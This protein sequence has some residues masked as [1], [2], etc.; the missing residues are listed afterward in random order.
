MDSHT[1]TQPIIRR[2]NYSLIY[3]TIMC[4]VALAV[5]FAAAALRLSSYFSPKSLENGL[6]DSYAGFVLPITLA[7]DEQMQPIKEGIL[8]KEI[9]ISDD[10][11]RTKVDGLSVYPITETDMSSGAAAG[12]VLVRDSDSGQSVDIKNLLIAPYPASLKDDK[13]SRLGTDKEPLVLIIH[14]HATESFACE[15]ENSYTAG[16]EFR[17]K[18]TE[19]NMVAVGRVMAGVLNARGIPTLHSEILHDAED[20]NASYDN[21]LATVKKY[22]QAYPS[23]KYVFDLHRDAMIRESGEA[24]KP[25]CEINGKKTAQ[26]MTLVG[27]DA[28]GAEHSMWRENNMNLAVKLQYNL[29]SEYNGMARPINLRKLSFHQQYAPGSLLFEIG[30]CGNTLEEAKNAAENL[31]NAIAD[32]INEN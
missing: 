10:S 9:Y 2:L 14:T 24:L 6:L 27:T 4:S 18:D 12:E 31:G 5:M 11:A 8:K 26:V 23:I 25:V 29:T 17:S 32:V 15:G 1:T 7:E 30:S 16:Y 20:Y 19:K 3:R 28:G 22:L 13:I 21:S